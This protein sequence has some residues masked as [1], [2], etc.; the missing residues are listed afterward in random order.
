[1]DQ[2]L[3]PR[4]YTVLQLMLARNLFIGDEVRVSTL[5]NAWNESGANPDGFNQALSI[6]QRDGLVRLSRSV[7]GTVAQLS[8]SGFALG[9]KQ[10][11]APLIERR[12]NSQATDMP[13][14]KRRRRVEY[15]ASPR[16]IRP[17][18]QQA[19][20]TRAAAEVIRDRAKV[21]H[22]GVFT[23]KANSPSPTAL[24]LCVLGLLRNRR[25]PPGGQ[26]DY[27][28]VL[29]EWMRMDLRHDDLLLAIQRLSEKR[30]LET[31]QHPRERLILTQ[32]GYDRYEKPPQS[33]DDGLDRWQAKKCLRATKRL[34]AL[35]AA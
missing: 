13:P 22:S 3:D 27:S 34:G 21:T 23:K 29:E 32:R 33:M 16:V 17:H 4:C 9:Q 8:K 28:C 19:S 1:M 15:L 18:E 5:G 20:K 6:L 7:N 30:E 31:L 14:P 11:S 2:T 26:I 24:Q 35:P 10:R 12:A 25:V